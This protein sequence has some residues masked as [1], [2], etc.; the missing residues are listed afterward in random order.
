MKR[1][2]FK[3]PIYY[4][5]YY[6]VHLHLQ[7]GSKESDVEVEWEPVEADENPKEKIYHL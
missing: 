7:G 2:T 6:S 3:N 5:A 1:V 4:F